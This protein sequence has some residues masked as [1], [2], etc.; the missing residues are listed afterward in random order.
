MSAEATVLWGAAGHARVLRDILGAER[1]E[2]VF[3]NAVVEPPWDV[4]LFVGREGFA[5]WFGSGRARTFAVAIGGGRGVDR[6]EIA[7]W[8]EHQGLSPLSVRHSR[9]IVEPSAELAPGVQVLA[10]AFVG[11]SA[12]IGRMA[13]LNSMSSIDHDCI[14]GE[15]CH[16]APRAVL[17]GEVT[18]GP[19]CF[20]GAGATILPKLRLGADVIVG[21]GATVTRDVPDGTTVIGTPAR[22]T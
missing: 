12:R 22:P 8:L 6:L 9:A 3:D 11:A 4:P 7:A 18:V 5:D 13:I 21:A 17:C 10:G 14:V 2:A 20:V 1:V 19:R 15:G 16:I